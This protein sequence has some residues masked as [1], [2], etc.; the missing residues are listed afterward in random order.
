M[1]DEEVPGFCRKF[2]RRVGLE[3]GGSLIVVLKVVLE[4]T[5]DY[6]V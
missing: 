3:E 6:I 2:I 4:L 5:C 1:G